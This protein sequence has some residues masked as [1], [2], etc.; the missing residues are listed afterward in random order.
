MTA[1]GTL[2]GIPQPDRWITALQAGAPRSV[3]TAWRL[4][5]RGIHRRH[6]AH[7][8]DW[9]AVAVARL[10]DAHR[11]KQS[12]TTEQDRKVVERDMRTCTAYIDRQLSILTGNPDRS[13]SGAGDADAA[14]TAT[15]LDTDL[16]VS[17]LRA[18][19]H[20]AARAYSAA[21]TPDEGDDPTDHEVT[22]PA[23]TR[24]GAPPW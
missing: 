24:P 5:I 22:D 12:A 21:I 16:R 3:R 17:E 2:A 6:P 15:W 23:S 10:V 20:A 7:G 18:A 9:M 4:G 8:T 13:V 14:I 11:R 19:L 1:P